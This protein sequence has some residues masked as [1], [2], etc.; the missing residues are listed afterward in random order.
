MVFSGVY[1]RRAA[2]VF[3]SPLSGLSQT[4]DADRRR[5]RLVSD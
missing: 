5:G 3:A 4:P 1:G 2:P